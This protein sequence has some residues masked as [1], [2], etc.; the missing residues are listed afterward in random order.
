MAVDQN[1]AVATSPAGPAPAFDAPNR[2]AE[3]KIDALLSS[4]PDTIRIV[5]EE[6]PPGS[7][8]QTADGQPETTDAAAAPETEVEET[9]DELET[10]AE[11]ETDFSLSDEDRDY[12]DAAYARA[13]K[14]WS[15]TFGQEVNPQDPLQRAM[16][17]EMMNRGEVI[18]KLQTKETK[19]PTAAEAAAATEQAA[20]EQQPKPFTTEQLIEQYETCK[21]GV[22]D[23]MYVPAVGERYA[24][25]LATEM[26]R[27]LW[28]KEYADRNKRVEVSPEQ[29]KALMRVMIAGVTLVT[30]NLVPTILKD[31]LPTVQRAYPELPTMHEERIRASALESLDT[32][33][34]TDGTPKYPDVGT[35]IENGSL[36]AQMAELEKSMGPIR[37]G[38]VREAY[39]KRLELAYKMARGERVNPAALQRAAEAGRSNATRT[40]RA[41]GA[42]RNAPG[43]STRALGS[44]KPNAGRSF[45]E[46]LVGTDEDK[47]AKAVAASEKK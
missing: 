13:A 31:V 25:D 27:A 42:A 7:T 19:E 23:T 29:S 47:F 35:F 34:N 30:G 22:A 2:E 41:A 21:T 40:A 17:R 43:A 44:T 15:K 18:S 8:T 5:S 45:M 10:A 14:H 11:E 9:T 1:T 37:G 26:A 33:K 6:E 4:E 24:S 20:V 12:S 3:A 16:L 39:S 46:S 32:A 36:K 28:P 38:N